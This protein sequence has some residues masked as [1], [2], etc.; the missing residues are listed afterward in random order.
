MTLNVPVSRKWNDSDR[1]GLLSVPRWLALK[2]LSR[3]VDKK[4]NSN[5]FLCIF[6]EPVYLKVQ[7]IQKRWGNL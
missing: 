1:D 4:Y 6:L 5:A 3:E 2:L 7:G